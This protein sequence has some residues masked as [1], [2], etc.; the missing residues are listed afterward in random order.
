MKR[1][2]VVAVCGRYPAWAETAEADY[3]KPLKSFSVVVHT[4]RPAATP[5]KEAPAILARLPQRARCLL[6]DSQGEA[7]DSARFAECLQQWL[8]EPPPLVW[9]VGGA[10]GVGA[11]VRQR[12]ERTV[13]LSP[14]TFPHSLARLILMEQLFRADCLARRH[15]YPR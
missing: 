6:L 8:A 1:I 7:V 13:S 9:I 10:N 11:A 14:L 3:Q 15:P 12:A 4:V 5:D 2:T